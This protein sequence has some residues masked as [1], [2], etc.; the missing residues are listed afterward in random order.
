MSRRHGSNSLDFSR[1]GSGGAGV[2]TQGLTCADRLGLAA[3]AL[4]GG[5]PRIGRGPRLET[6]TK[7]KIKLT[8]LQLVLLSAAAARPDFM[9]LP[10]PE[11]VR[12]KGKMLERALARLRDTGWVEEVAARHDAEAWCDTEDGW[13]F[14]LRIA[15]AGLE[16]IGLPARAAED[17]EDAETVIAAAPATPGEHGEPAAA[18]GEPE[19]EE[20]DAPPTVIDAASRA[21][22][23]A[24]PEDEA[25]PAKPLFRPGTK[26]ARLVEM[27]SAPEEA[28]IDA[29][30]EALGWQAHTTRAALTGLRKKGLAV[31]SAKG[32]DGRTVYWLGRAE[33]A[34]DAA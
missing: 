11:S 24:A 33:A 2:A 10:P 21:A 31:E 7:T 29:L 5:R 14:G 22:T 17:A 15:P 16:A 20:A 18:D 3:G 25:A 23:D 28:D 30:S 1:T 34:A 26:Q 4:R 12:A 19:P 13:S 32:A 27:I 8:D 9:L 6:A